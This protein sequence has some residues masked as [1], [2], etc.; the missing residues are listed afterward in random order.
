[1]VICATSKNARRSR[2]PAFLLALACFSWLTAM[3]S[4]SSCSLLTI[5]SPEKPLSRR[6]LNARILTHEY[7][8]HFI[9]AIEQTADEI[10][11]DSPDSQVRLNTLRWKIATAAASQRAA[12][13]IV[14]M[15]SLFD[16][17]ALSVQMAQFLDTGAGRTLF[18]AQQPRAVTL[19]ASLAGDARSLARGLTSSEEYARDEHFIEAYALEHPLESLNFARASVVEQWVRE[20]GPESKLVD[21]L[22]TVPESLADARDLLRMY[23]DNAPEQ[24]L[25]RAQLIGQQ[26]GVTG[27]DVQSALKQLD[28]RMARLTDLADKTPDLVNGT[29]RDVQKRLE[30]SWAQMLG[31]LRYQGTALSVALDTQR[32]AATRSINEQ[33]EAITADAERISNELLRQAGAE[34]RQLVR[35]ALLLVIVLAVIVLGLPFAA[36]YLVGR[37]RRTP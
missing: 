23:G 7:A 2:P 27:Q 22:G 14:P 12:G 10:A 26:S 28:A 6:D 25:W 33:R 37:G 13:Q 29:V 36:G 31:E 19:T 1:L 5:K 15:M 34:A 4:L 3:A 24:M 20:S 17:W 35:E 9:S 30:A 11:A 16:T 32:E 8:A 21:S 18:G